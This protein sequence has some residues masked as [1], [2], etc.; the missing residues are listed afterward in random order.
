MK[1]T[2]HLQLMA[3]GE[4]MQYIPPATIEAIRQKDDHPLFRAYCIGEEGNATPN[5]IGMGG[6][7]LN[8]M[9]AAISA[10]VT[11]LQFGT[12]IFLNHAATN[13][14]DGRTVVGELV[15]KAL[16]YIGGKMRAVAVTYIYP[17]YRDVPADAASIEADIEVDP[18]GRS[19]VVDGVH[20]LGVTGIA[21]GDSRYNKPAFA[22]AGLVAQL[23]AFDIQGNESG[24]TQMPEVTI[25][26]I[27]DFI[28]IRRLD[29]SEVFSETAIG[30]D[31]KVRG[32]VKAEFDQRTRLEKELD[33]L[34]KDGTAKV[35]KLEA[36]NKTLR[37]TLVGG[38]AQA[39]AQAIIVERKMPEPRARFIALKIPE[40]KVEGEVVDDATIKT[41]LNKFIDSQVDEFTKLEQ[42]FTGKPAE[43]DKGKNDDKGAAGAGNQAATTTP[44][45]DEV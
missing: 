21:V 7:V 2:V 36:D 8:W 44:C 32:L 16:E 18:S 43:G 4:I 40:F 42:V 33:D 17:Q 14:H 22:A 31:P 34:K 13:E 37:M 15:G 10:M 1:T 35:T 29:P 23:Q 30:R 39:L 9:R 41:Q 45:I 38:K 26:T 20:L 6:R 28:G 19:N 24:G 27:K 12:K 5:V 3:A 11:K 25:E